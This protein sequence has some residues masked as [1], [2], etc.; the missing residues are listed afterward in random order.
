MTW[1]G[2][3]QK[4][5][6]SEAKLFSGFST[7]VSE[8]SVFFKFVFAPAGHQRPAF[9]FPRV[10]PSPATHPMIVAV[11]IINLMIT[12]ISAVQ[13]VLGHRNAAYSMQYARITEQEINEALDER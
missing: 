11:F 1:R 9:L 7:L 3:N 10:C 5:P 12:N 6:G 4:Q 13:R 8:H 2:E